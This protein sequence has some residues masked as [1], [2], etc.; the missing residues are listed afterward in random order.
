MKGQDINQ[1]FQNMPRDIVYGLNPDLNKDLL[2][3]PKDTTVFVGTMI[4]EKVKRLNLN[5]EYISLKTSDVGTTEI[6]L[7]PLINNSKIICVVQTVNSTVSDSKISFYTDKWKPIVND[8]LFPER[9]IEWFIK[10]DVD[11]TSEKYRHAMTAL[12]MMTPMKI[13]LSP[14]EATAIV[15]FDPESFLSTEDYKIVEPFLTKVPKI[16][17]WDK[18][19]F[20]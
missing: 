1:V 9:N 11:K 4:Y 7:L 19:R 3:R 18:V 8:E 13:S 5:S 17:E 10:P 16:L 12:Q 20:K 15:D 14:D 2:E 6:K